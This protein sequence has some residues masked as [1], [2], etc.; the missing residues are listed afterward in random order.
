MR[1]I[2]ILLLVVSFAIPGTAAASAT[3]FTTPQVLKAFFPKSE[4]VTYKR[5]RLGEAERKRL[6]DRLGYAPARPEY[7][8]FVAMT[9]ERID[10]YAI[11]DDERGQHEP[12]TFAV[13]ISPAGVVERQEV[14]VSREKYGEEISDPRF[15]AQFEG[16]SGKDQV[17][18]GQDVD[19][20]SGATISSRSMAVGVRRAIA[21]VD[22]LVIAPAA[23]SG[24]HAA[25]GS[26]KG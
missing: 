16:K 4:R 2:A 20:I 21:I 13:K 14:M 6:A 26:Q 8:V 12:I 15:R 10:G 25:A 1:L 3:Y 5:L 7:V 22:E 23:L 24:N 17:R 19:V 9:G 11:I 18:A